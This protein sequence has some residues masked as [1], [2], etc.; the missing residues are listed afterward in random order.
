MLTLIDGREKVFLG[1]QRMTER[2]NLVSR[3]RV[4][5]K[6][7]PGR[8]GDAHLV[9]T[10]STPLMTKKQ[11][12]MCK[13]LLSFT[14]SYFCRGTF[15]TGEMRFAVRK[16]VDQ[17]T[18]SQTF[19]STS[20]DGHCSGPLSAEDTSRHKGTLSRLFTFMNVHILSSCHA[21]LNWEG[22]RVAAQY[23]FR[24]SKQ[25]I[26]N[27]DVRFAVSNEIVGR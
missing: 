6:Y 13:A 19:L 26:V 9:L 16:A 8:G 27:T 4:V 12:R 3:L 23:A 14:L 21:Q 24:I 7:T 10:P 22:Y 17:G 2:P 1:T 18:D 11:Y 20:K 25:L 5:E 15:E